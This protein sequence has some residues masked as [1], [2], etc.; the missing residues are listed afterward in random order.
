[1]LLEVWFCYFNHSLWSDEEDERNAATGYLVTIRG[2]DNQARPLESVSG[3]YLRFRGELSSKF[4][5]DRPDTANLVITID[6]IN[7]GELRPN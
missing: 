1:M 7:L 2:G 4:V 6:G 3:K 5:H